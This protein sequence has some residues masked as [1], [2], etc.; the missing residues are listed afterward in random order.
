MKNLTI[1]DARIEDAERFCEIYNPYVL[2]TSISFEEEAVSPEAMRK[3]I[4]TKLE[5]YSWIAACEGERVLG[6]AYYGPWRERAAYAGTVETSVY[7]DEG[8]RGQGLGK[9]LYGALLDR[10]RAQGRHVA[11]GVVALPN[12]AS[13][14]LQRSFGFTRAAVFH[15]VGFKAGTW[16]DIAFWE[17]KL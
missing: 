16:V 15:E 5:R 1:R 13:E 3:R 9:L 8:A 4:A 7:L 11:M 12:E 17:L 14:A 10:A 6:Y 2:G